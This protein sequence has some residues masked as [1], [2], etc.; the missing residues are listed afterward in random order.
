MKWLAVTTV[1][2]SSLSVGMAEGLTL[3]EH[4]VPASIEAGSESAI[5]IVVANDGPLFWSSEEGFAISYHWLDTA[6]EAVVW[7][8][9]RTPLPERVVPGASIELTATVE[10][11]RRPGDYLLQ[12]DVVQ[13]GVRWLSETD[14]TEPESIAVSVFAGRAFSVLEAAAPRVMM[15][16]SVLEV[17]LVLQNEG[18]R[19]WTADGSIAA[20]YHWLGREGA[21]V[22]PKGRSVNWEGR[23]SVFPTEVRGGETV[24]LEAVVVAPE[25]PGLWRLQ[26]DLVEEGVCWFS[27]RAPDPPA[28]FRVLVISDPMASGFWWSL[29]VLCAGAAAVTTLRSGGPRVLVTLF[30]NGDVVWCIAALSVKQ[31]I[32]LAESG[33]GPT[34]TGWILIVAGASVLV[35]LTRVL[36]ARFRGWACWGLV[37]SAT[38]LF[39]ADS[40][41]LRFFADLPSA[42]AAASIGQLGQVEASVRE[43][44][45]PGDLWL[46][47]D[48]LPGM[49]LVLVANRLR[50]NSAGRQSRG[51]VVGLL[52][53]T[54]AGG[55]VAAYLAL[56]PPELLAQVFRRVAVA[57]EVGVLNLHVVDGAR[58]VARSVLSRELEPAQF[59]D[60]VEWFRERAPQRAGS[61]D[62]FATAEGANLVM[63]QVES[64]QAFVIGLEI[65][66]REVTPFLNR[67]AQE[68]LWF[69]NVTDQTGQGRSSDSELATQVSLLP[70]AGGAAA[71]RYADNGYTGVAEALGERG[72][73]TLSAVPYDGAF[74]NRRRTHPAY[75]YA[76]SLFVEDFATG[77]NVGWGLSDRDFLAQ[78]ARELAAVREPFAAYLLTLSLHHPFDGFPNHLKELDVGG[79]DG[80]PF[81]NFLHTMHFFDASLAAFVTALE[82]KGLAGNTVIAIWGDHDAGF[83]W[84]SEIAAAMGATHDAAGW[85]LSQEVPLFVK[86]PGIET[87]RGERTMPAG[88]ADVAPTLLALLGVDPVDYA[89]VGRNLLGEPGDRPVVGEYGCWRNS[90]LLF[91]QGDGSL[92]DGTCIELGAMAVVSSEE[93]R[94]GFE[95]AQRTE[96]VSSLVLEY[97]L[98]RA[99]RHQ[100]V[101]DPGIER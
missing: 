31:R 48:L 57:E 44:L 22:H 83:P 1:F 53:M 11:P 2:L 43:L 5:Q 36:P 3:V 50:R 15:A 12:W 54:A 96:E 27:D 20:A 41:Y 9:L 98:Q 34:L 82:D 73:H 77:E 42:S 80:T 65:G 85:Y 58:S 38:L 59:D 62:L 37:A 63:V 67:W 23:R 21:G 76:Q 88:H 26:W 10:A 95:E 6:G 74:W 79:W 51:V 14:T 78:A 89:F 101:A 18:N 86:V 100:L 52:A 40:V 35:L 49:A 91:L 32:V 30:A 24:A 92:D 99:L 93:C 4:A 17:A 69:S 87:V 90:N 29:L 75:G 33:A 39:W 81:G 13:E 66:G 45:A 84:R 61:G 28:A 56:T 8:G 70:M 7:D 46:W 16:G 68:A 64:L 72:Y 47:L 71:F 55:L 25:K 60:A 19:T 94:Q 97:D